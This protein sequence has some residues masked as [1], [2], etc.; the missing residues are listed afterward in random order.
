MQISLTWLND[1]VPIAEIDP[2]AVAEALTSLGLEVESIAQL[3]PVKGALL[4]GE[5][6]AAAPHPNADKLQVCEVSVG[7]DKPLAIVCGAPNARKGLK[8][9]VAMVGS[10]LPGGLKIK[11]TQIRNQLSQG[12][13][14][15][16]K[17]LGLS[18]SH[19]GIIELSNGARVG[20]SATELLGLA[21]TV[22]TVS[23]T[24]N[25]GDCLS[26]L[27]IAR[28]LAAKFGLSLMQPE[29]PHTGGDKTL[30]T[31]DKVTV[32]IADHED[33][34]RFS[35]LYVRDVSHVASPGWL[36]RRLEAS[37]LRP[38]N[39][40]VDITN[41]VML[42]FG[43]P[44]HAYDER[45][46][47]GKVIEVRRARNGESVVTLD[48]Q[49]RELTGDDIVIADAK[50]AVGLAGIMGG[51]NSA[52]KKDTKNIV[53][54]VAQ[55]H[56][57]KVRKTARR[58]GL[59]TEASHRFE[60]G[61]DVTA[62]MEVALRVAALL[63]RCTTELNAQGGQHLVPVH[64]SEA[65]DAYPSPHKPG[66]VALRLTRARQVLGLSLLTQDESIAHLTRLGF[67]CLD[68]TDGRMLFAVPSF[69][70]DIEREVDLIE[71]IAR[72]MGYDKIPMTLPMME[73]GAKLEDPYIGFT[74]SAKLAMAQCGMNETISFPFIAV[75]DLDKLNV[76]NDHPFRA[77]VGLANPLADDQT[78]LQPCLI[79]NLLK[80]V[81]A[82]RR[83]G[84][85]GARLFE[86]ARAF[87]K[88]GTGIVDPF[89]AWSLWCEQ[90]RHISGRGR[91]DPRPIERS[92]IAGILDQP[93]ADK[94]WHGG[95]EPAT[96][97]TGKA[98]VA[99]FFATFG[100]REPTLKPVAAATLPWLVP[101][102][103]AAIHIDGQF[104]GYCGEVHP[105]TVLAYD[106]ELDEA[107][108]VFE[109]DLETVF[110]AFAQG[111]S[112]RTEAAKFPPVTRD[113][114]L[115][116]ARTVTHEEM[117]TT[118]ARAPKHKHL[119][120]CRLFDVYYGE[121]L[122]PDKKSMAYSLAFRSP[123]RTLKD[124]EVDQEIAGLV[125][126]LKQSIGAEQR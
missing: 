35:A 76:A 71:E 32:K 102:Q 74:E 93:Y 69:R 104:A 119:T 122:P 110:N 58:M 68:K 109:L 121:N 6:L 91:Q 85:K 36:A 114:A 87:R 60:R 72:L 67:S 22:L 48:G 63:E 18:G 57:S 97:F 43:H 65:V 100:V 20:T 38:L 90:G 27:G 4:V 55:F 120:S 47:G 39:L 5:I 15:S 73:I 53:I 1:Y 30:H 105:Q 23:V 41:Y 117:T 3:A 11:E 126:W 78:H 79:P 13:L 29:G 59:H 44:I 84:R 7:R 116:V 14:C 113:V 37:G 25:R 16:E 89:L 82:N 83:H 101:G 123:D 81:A 10:E 26:Y 96:F 33:C 124:E 125:E 64:A 40:V 46:I 118:V 86:L 34:G 51:E 111:K 17:E 45:E 9:A 31:A 75:R 52:I 106:L 66:K 94:S 88:D 80:A 112:F 49:K 62:T 61:V 56:P 54:E 42:E 95:I 98:I 108:I 12:M 50:N 115:V 92:I 8:V 28:E 70:H 103:S 99:E 21:D 24:P 77:L 19:D 107:P 2:T